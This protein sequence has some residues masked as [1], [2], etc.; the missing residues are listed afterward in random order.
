MGLSTALFPRFN[1]ETSQKTSFLNQRSLLSFFGVERHPFTDSL[2]TDF[3]YQSTIHEEALLK[4]QMSVEYDV[5]FALI[6]GKSGT[7]KTLLSQ[8]LLERLP[9]NRFKPILIPVTPQQSPSSFLKIIL[10]ALGEKDIAKNVH[11]LI[12]GISERILEIS[13]SGIKPVF[14]LDECHFLSAESLQLLR[15]LSNFESANKK[16]ITCLLFAENSFLRRLSYPAYASLKSRMYLR[17]FLEPLTLEECK[18]Y[19][20]FRLMSAGLE[21]ADLF[22]DSEIAQIHAQ[23]GGIPRCINQECFQRMAHRFL[24]N[25]FNDDRF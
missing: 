17:V 8:I 15:T 16:L 25:F 7:G 9:K 19:I 22:D 10:T 23:S 24:G 21:K 4:M 20:H 18:Q 12:Q 6:T 5:S 3:F 13:A 14:F 2:N 11:A 1:D